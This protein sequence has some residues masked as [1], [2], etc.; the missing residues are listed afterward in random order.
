MF[1]TR[2]FEK[3]AWQRTAAVSA[4]LARKVSGVLMAARGRRAFRPGARRT[5]LPGPLCVQVQTIDRCNASCIMCPYSQRVPAG[6]ANRMSNVLYSRL[7]AELA[8]A[9]T[10]RFYTLMLQNEPLMDQQIA[11]RVEEASKTLGSGTCIEIVTNGSLLHGERADRLLK[12]GLDTLEVS[13]DAM[14]EDTYGLIRKGLDFATVKKNLHEFLRRHDRPLVIARFLKQ[15]ANEGEEGP[16]V[17][18]W[19]AHG[20]GVFVH[21]VVNRAGMVR[22]FDRLYRRR[23]APARRVL[24]SILRRGFPFCQQ[25]FFALNV[26]WDG[27]VLLCCHDWGPSVVVGDLTSQSLPEIWNG[28]AMNSHRHLLYTGRSDE[29]SACRGC[30]GRWGPWGSGRKPC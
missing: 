6:R 23:I 12:A 20:A 3:W 16:F 1:R 14:E 28:E 17:A 9:G 10:T 8:A 19:K 13:V 22:R 15:R 7:L 18:H 29:I 24:H 30:S 21:S 5:R 25:P 27:R 11:G 2:A 26:L 4:D